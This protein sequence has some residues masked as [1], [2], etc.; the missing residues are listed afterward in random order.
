MAGAFSNITS[1]ISNICEAEKS[2]A[3][4]ALISSL[5]LGIGLLGAGLWFYYTKIRKGGDKKTSTLAIS[6][7]LMLLGIYFLF[8]VLMYLLAPYIF[9][10]LLPSG[11]STSCRP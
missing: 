3:N 11:A 2:A 10:N 7:V 4:F 8:Q 5:V 6:I 1:A 9:Q